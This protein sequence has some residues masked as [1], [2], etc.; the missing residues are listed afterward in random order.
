MTSETRDDA[1]GAR[2]RAEEILTSAGDAINK[3]LEDIAVETEQLL[4]SAERDA[5]QHRIKVEEESARYMEESKVEA[6]R[7]RREA[8]AIR[9]EAETMRRAAAAEAS[10]ITAV[11][12]T[13]ASN[14]RAAANR[15]AEAIVE[16]ARMEH[17]RLAIRIPELRDA[18][19]QFEA[20]VHA[21]AAEP[22]VD[23]NEIEAA[24]LGA[25]AAAAAPIEVEPNAIEAPIAARV[26]APPT[27]PQGA[28]VTE[29]RIMIDTIPL[30]DGS[31]TLPAA[32]ELV[33]LDQYRAFKEPPRSERTRERE[34]AAAVAAPE[35]EPQPEPTAAAEAPLERLV[36]THV[37]SRGM[38]SDN[39]TIY[40]RRGGGLRRRIKAQGDD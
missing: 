19:S 20:Q 39:D 32:R 40:Q 24:E 7:M 26:A 34:V 14:L 16:R 4:R 5:A 21:L 11:A 37:A 15:E 13:E 12:E 35:A 18:L 36:G 3:M 31:G 38:T 17:D 1:A 22:V 2:R 6:D 8:E 27:S 28:F 25:V 33:D 9:T 30:P 10:E 29:S 23:L